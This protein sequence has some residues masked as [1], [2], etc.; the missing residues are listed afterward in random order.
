MDFTGMGNLWFP[1]SL[2]LLHHVPCLHPHWNCFQMFYHFCATLGSFG[3]NI[4]FNNNIIWGWW[5]A[6]SARY[7]GISNNTLVKVYYL[8]PKHNL[9]P[10]L[11]MFIWKKV[12]C[13]QHSTVLT[14]PTYRAVA[15]FKRGLC[16]KMRGPHPAQSQIQL[17]VV[18]VTPQTSFYVSLG[19][20]CLNEDCR[21]CIGLQQGEQEDDML[22]SAIWIME[23]SK[24]QSNTPVNEDSHPAGDNSPLVVHVQKSR[25]IYMYVGAFRKFVWDYPY[26]HV[27]VDYLPHEGQTT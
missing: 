19:N 24:K 9:S 11:W 16:Q 27:N 23:M 1:P 22:V 3:R 18:V 12:T 25:E 15:L 4:N 17:S 7:S 13:P 8:K 21:Y 14:L 2:A 10:I 20:C 26:S 6:P 5:E